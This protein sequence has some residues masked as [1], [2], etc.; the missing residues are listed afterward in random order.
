M[1]GQPVR[2][3]LVGVGMIAQFYLA[4]LARHPRARLVAVADRDARALLALR[5]RVPTYT[6]HEELLHRERPDA[7]VVTVPNDQ[8]AAICHSALTTGAAVC[9]E[10]PLATRL[11]D[12]TALVEHARAA[13][14]P[15]FTAFHRRYNHAVRALRH[16]LPAGVP[17]DEVSVRYWERIEEHTGPDAWYLDPARCGGGCLADNGPNAFDLLRLLLGEVEVTGAAL[18]YD[19]RG[20]DRHATV[21]LHTTAG[22]RA[23]VDLDWSYPGE[24]KHIEVRLSDGTVHRADLLSGHQGF[25]ASLWHE[26]RGVLAEFTA[27]CAGQRSGSEPEPGLAA[28]AL[29]AQA[30]RAA[31]PHP[32]VARPW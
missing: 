30:Y 29:V 19:A 23:T 4:A 8:H 25:K 18:R 6:D 20:V 22:P 24:E 16:R 1:G 27:L 12:A 2:I 10:K 11:D 21:H 13:R 32:V 14:R 9:V 26:Y 31:N 5:G 3:G 28:L 15:L 17:I 7:L